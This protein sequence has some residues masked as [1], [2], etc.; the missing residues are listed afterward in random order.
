MKKS[1]TMPTE[2]HPAFLELAEE[3]LQQAASLG[4]RALSGLIP[5]GDAYEGFAPGG[6]Q[7]M[8]ERGYLW[9]S[10]PGGDILVEV[11]VYPGPSRYDAGAIA[12]AVIS[13]P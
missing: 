6:H 1:G 3:E 13:K 10:E 2:P 12:R 4:W 9:Q 7:V 5:W 11:M 8:I